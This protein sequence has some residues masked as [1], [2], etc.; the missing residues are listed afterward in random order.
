MTRL[1]LAKF[2]AAIGGMGLALSAATGIAS[3]SPEDAVINTTCSYPQVI[4]ALD[5]TNPAAAE[6][7]H[8]SPAAA[9]Y[10]TSFLNSPPPQRAGMIAQLR[11][12]PGAAQYIGVVEQ[13]A[14]VCNNY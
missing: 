6:Q 12:L 13:V 14:G 9:N 2:A 5:A 4:A 1:S 10:L 8:A 7:F 11:I 3:A